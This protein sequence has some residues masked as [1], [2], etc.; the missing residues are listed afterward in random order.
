[1]SQQQ[2]RRLVTILSMD[3]A[4]FSRLMHQNERHTVGAIT[5]V[6]RDR[7]LPATAHH[8]G[9]VF[10][11]MGDGFLAEFSSPVAAVEMAAAF[12][13]DTVTNPVLDSTGAPMLAR[14]GIVLADVLVLGDDRF[15]EGVNL[16]VRLQGLAPP[17]GIAIS[18][19]V[20]E[21][22]DGKV[23]LVFA[24]LGQRKLKNIDEPQ[25]VWVW[26]AEG[27]A[28]QRPTPTGNP[29]RPSIVILPF[30]NLSSD[31]EQGYFAD[32]MTEELTATLSRIRDFLVIA[33]NTAFTYKG[34]P[35]DV[36]EISRELGVRYVLE[37]SVRRAGDRI[38]VSAQLI[39]AETGAHIW[40][41]KYEG[42]TANVFD[43]Q[44]LI[45]RQVAGAVYPSIRAAE[46]ERAQR[47]RPES[48]EAY[49]LVMR[50]LPELWAH[51]MDA[52]LRAIAL[53]ENAL[54]FDPDY[55]LAA[56]LAAWAH[57]QQIVY[58]WTADFAAE[59]NKGLPLI[60]IAVRNVGDDPTAM[61]AIAS[62]T[63]LLEGNVRRSA[64]FVNR[65]LAI[66]PNHA[67]AWTRRGFL[68]VYAGESGKALSDFNMAMT[69]SPRD[70]FAFHSFIGIGLAHFAAGNI[71]AAIHWVRRALDSRPGM[72][73]PYRDL[74]VFLAHAG[75]PDEARRALADFTYLR[76][77][78]TL[79][80]IADGL[81]FM[82][83]PL[84]ERYIAGLRL[85]GLPE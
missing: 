82:S 46:I 15:S 10:K 64:E 55:G 75:K 34:R 17:G 48:L 19:G 26:P 28:G 6:Y 80:S 12:Q 11:T 78:M 32:G 41:D 68:H 74:A 35:V 56:G 18:R 45:A 54:Q 71:D 63:I 61:T 30:D 59:R 40:S 29:G 83:P 76:P 49:D 73:W 72:T 42:E 44:D 53:L 3:V 84:L 66:D 36:R 47:K 57:A 24:A 5:E 33:R 9:A 65:A 14:I 81:R 70:P 62:A 52:N 4:G 39:E 7:I 31:P 60:E 58:N 2:Q 13:S 16:A 20:K 50:A 77:E 27:K 79:S 1:M 85:A 37:G 23:D 25:D 43:L 67:W 51:R 8:G 69:L 38:R 22:L 21:Y